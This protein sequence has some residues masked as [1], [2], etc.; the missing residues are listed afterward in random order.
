MDSILK[1]D[2]PIGTKIKKIYHI[3]DI[4][5][6]LYK[7]H[8]EYNHVFGNLYSFLKKDIQKYKYELYDSILVVTGDILHSKTEL[9]PESI[10]LTYDLF[11]ELSSI[12]P[13]VVIAGNHDANLSN[14]NR[15]DSLSPIIGSLDMNPDIPLFYLKNTGIYEM[16]NITFGVTSVFDYYLLKADQL[17]NKQGNIKI[18]LF[19][20]RVNGA[21][22]D[23]GAVLDGEHN[24]LIEEEHDSKIED[25][26]NNDAKDID[27]MTID[28]NKK[29][30]NNDNH[31]DICERN[32]ITPKSF[33][34]YDYVLLGDIH[35]HQYLNK[36]K[37]I[38]YAGSLIQ[39]NH[40]ELIK[41]HG[42]LVWD[43]EA[44]T[45][46]LV[47]I[48]NKYGYYSVKIKNDSDPVLNCCLP[49]MNTKYHLN[50]QHETYKLQKIVKE[51]VIKYKK[52]DD[53]YKHNALCPIPHNVRLRIEYNN[54]T[55][56]QQEKIVSLIKL[57]HNIAETQFKPYEID[58]DEEKK[59]LQS[60]I[61]FDIKD[62]KCQN[63]F[64]DKYFSSKIKEKDKISNDD[65]DKIK[66]LNE[67]LNKDMAMEHI[68]YMNWKL[69]RLEFDN[70]FSYDA[71]NIIDFTKCSGVVGIIAPN[72]TGKSAIIDIIMYCLFNKFSRKGDVK[73]MVNI[74]SN[75]FRAYLVFRIGNH[76]YHI[77]KFGEYSS[78]KS[79]RTS[80]LPVN[81]DFYKTDLNGENKV[82]LKEE[83]PKDTMNKIL[84][85]VG[86]YDD[87]ILTSVS[88][89]GNNT[90]FID[91]TD[92]PRKTE[93]EK[94]LKIDIFSELKDKASKVVNEKKTVFKYLKS[95]NIV[96]D[97]TNKIKDTTER[98]EKYKKTKTLLDELQVKY[99]KSETNLNKVKNNL[100]KLESQSNTELWTEIIN[101]FTMGNIGFQIPKLDL[102]KLSQNN[103]EIKET[104]NTYDMQWKEINKIDKLNWAELQKELKIMFQTL[105]KLVTLMENE[106]KKLNIKTEDNEAID[107]IKDNIDKYETKLNKLRSSLTP[108]DNIN[109]EEI[110]DQIDSI[111]SEK[112][113][114][115]TKLK[116]IPNDEEN[117]NKKLKEAVDFLQKY[118]NMIEE[119]ENERDKLMEE[120]NE[121]NQELLEKDK[122][123]IIEKLNI[124]NQ[125]ICKSIGEELTKELYEVIDT[126]IN[127]IQ[128]NIK[129]IGVDT[130]IAENIDK[131]NEKIKKCNKKVSKY[132]KIKTEA[133][134]EKN[135]INNTKQ[136]IKHLIKQL[137]WKVTDYHK[138]IEA[139][140]N[141]IEIN[142]NILVKENKLNELKK[143]VDN[144]ELIQDYKSY[145]LSIVTLL[146]TIN[147]FLKKIK[148]QEGDY[149][150]YRSLQNE[151]TE[152]E[153]TYNKIKSDKD[154][155]QEAYYQLKSEL[156]TDKTE[157]VELNK[158]KQEIQTLEHEINLYN[159]Y[160]EAVKNIPYMLIQSIK[161]KLEQLINEM[162]SALVDFT[163]YFDIKDNKHISIYIKRESEKN[164]REVLLSNASGFEKFIG[165]L[166]IR[167]ALINIS[168]LPKPNFLFIDEGW[169]CFDGDN[170]NNVGLIFEY[171]KNKF[172]FI[173]TIS[174]LQELRQ[175]LNQHIIL[176]KENGWS[177]VQY[178]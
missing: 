101:K 20:G 152:L 9:S 120:L 12:L 144:L 109:I 148:N 11:Y 97:I 64:L 102:K 52:I 176:K 132:Q 149:V 46:E 86:S 131:L 117:I 75:K 51:G 100:L 114:L 107:R 60:K 8:D 90:N 42:V 103:E 156:K 104:Y 54:L 41:G 128:E 94:L 139:N 126:S 93:M 32:K 113:D 35:K 14:K 178:T 25:V 141:N 119:T 118:S 73:D 158:K 161:P 162:L 121:G 87:M 34:G 58:E 172:D 71:N 130:S 40:G 81:V 85:Y 153:S 50:H 170:I 105:T 61:S 27:L 123:K 124:T 19:H 96:D 45:S 29:K 76:L 37:T 80:E 98:K 7:K 33:D 122:K 21:V 63:D 26:Y 84:D 22:T 134:Q 70:M 15:L 62:I 150:R 18:A 53:E 83:K 140:I 31:F 135:K 67:E 110:K 168:N 165:G 17:P 125:Q 59:E 82:S 10:Q 68:D 28:E 137:D 157:I 88:L 173:L 99:D 106:Q 89:Q 177:H 129:D 115:E 78:S 166:F 133:E 111:E 47:E 167:I 155:T 4:H 23:M 138:N 2:V 136:K 16:G 91:I 66:E 6:N 108:L 169:G 151:Y 160:L 174:H 127:D 69:I 1:I 143:E 36:Q 74:K 13:V 92:T 48:N 77:D 3:S 38:A 163:I 72:F 24:G 164:R 57:N 79:R 147:K 5:I 159:N 95:L 116:E 142:K 56:A 175:H 55:Y 65:I 43:L 49:L 171:L 112:Q 44:K 154:R 39:Q 146:N 145:S 30:L